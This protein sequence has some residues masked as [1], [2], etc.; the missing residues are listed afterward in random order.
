MSNKYDMAFSI[1]I[2]DALNNNTESNNINS[3]IHLKCSN[4]INVWKD[5]KDIFNCKLCK[6]TFG[7]FN[8]KHHCRSCGDI[9][10]YSCSD[11]W[12]DLCDELKIKR[13]ESKDKTS[14]Y[15]NSLMSYVP[16]YQNNK[17]RVCNVCHTKILEFST[18]KEICKNDLVN[19]DVV[20]LLESLNKRDN[21]LFKKAIFYNLSKFNEIIT[22]HNLSNYTIDDVEKILLNIDNITGHNKWIKLIFKLSNSI[23]TIGDDSKNITTIKQLIGKPRIVNCN[24]LNCSSNCSTHLDIEDIIEILAYDIYHDEIEEILILMFQEKI[25]LSMIILFLHLILEIIYIRIEEKNDYKI[26]DIIIN[27]FGDNKFFIYFYMYSVFNKRYHNIK[28]RIDD[29]KMTSIISAI[30]TMENMNSFLNTIINNSNPNISLDKIKSTYS[31]IFNDDVKIINPVKPLT[32]YLSI[33]VDNIKK[34]SSA[35]KPLMIP[36]QYK[37]KDSEILK[38]DKIIY[39]KECL[40]KDY[41]VSKIIKF[42][43]YILKKDLGFENC[44]I[45]YSII[46][47]SDTD[48]FIEVV[49]KADTI[50]NIKK[51]FSI[52]NYILENN[53]HKNI[54]EIRNIYMKSVAAYCI[55]TLL[56]S[57]GDR[58]LDNIMIHESGCLFHIDYS[59]ILGDDPKFNSSEAR[60]T[61]EMLEAFGGINSVNMETF[62]KICGDIFV[63]V[64]NHV[65]III[66]SL[67]LLNDSIDIEKLRK[68]IDENFE[69]D[70]NEEDA[71][72]RMKKK[73]ENSCNSWRGFV[74]DI[75]H[76]NRIS[77]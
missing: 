27:L 20:T 63:C 13:T 76:S 25:N 11:N 68:I 77:I 61:F 28:S 6:S 42:V 37:T 73:I 74:T 18:I 70:I 46:P 19:N 43:S 14:Y 44:V 32:K 26:I 75:M 57:V 40:Q 51:K 5:D 52:L 67:Q 15:L 9:F 49:D 21:I 65:N 23:K 22:K 66:Q 50:M 3:F 59:Y 55:I 58:H 72:N 24:I 48:G 39:K 30:D 33:D 41:I 31:T 47:F 38:I 29:N 54:E 69:L 56:L 1:Y 10:C 60:M 35:C 64:R 34:M 4:W 7:T 53:P 71:K 8:R 2:D 12:I 45:S 36:I 17:K 16:S 62:W